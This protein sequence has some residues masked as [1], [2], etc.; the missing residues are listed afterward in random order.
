MSEIDLGANQVVQSVA[1][2]RALC[3]S[4]AKSIFSALDQRFRKKSQRRDQRLVSKTKRLVFFFDISL[5]ELSS[6]SRV[7]KSLLGS[8]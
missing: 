4:L 6:P 1:F 8:K 3:M 5:G 2:V 7:P